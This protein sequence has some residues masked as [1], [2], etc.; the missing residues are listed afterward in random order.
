M[1]RFDSVLEREDTPA[2]LKELMR[3]ARNHI[4]RIPQRYATQ[5]LSEPGPMPTD[6]GVLHPV[7]PV[8]YVELEGGCR[9]SGSPGSV[10]EN[11]LF[12]AEKESGNIDPDVEYSLVGLAIGLDKNGTVFDL[13]VLRLGFN[14]AGERIPLEFFEDWPEWIDDLDGVARNI[15]DF[16]AQPS[17]HIE[18]EPGIHKINRRRRKRRKPPISAYHIIKWSEFSKPTNNTG[19]GGRH[20]IRYDVRGNWATYTNGALAGR[21][22]WRRAHQRG[23]TNEIFRPKGYQR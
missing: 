19:R 9:C 12:L 22:I 5:I 15:V 4:I 13:K 18:H 6:M 1:L 16:L 10:F 20:Q 8:F 23:L 7:F 11:F 14:T 2:H 21:R 3:E 17:V